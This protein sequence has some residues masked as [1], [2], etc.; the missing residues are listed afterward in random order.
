MF[1]KSHQKTIK[2]A[3][4]AGNWFTFLSD[5][6]RMVYCRFIS[7]RQFLRVFTTYCYGKGDQATQGNS[8]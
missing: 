4:K 1:M 7:M 5:G 2:A 3:G 8:S 6:R